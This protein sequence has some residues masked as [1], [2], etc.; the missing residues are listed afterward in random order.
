MGFDAA[1]SGQG[2]LECNSVG[3]IQTTMGFL[4]DRCTFPR[5]LLAETV[6]IAR[7]LHQFAGGHSMEVSHD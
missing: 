1:C 2:F 4:E 3:F 7:H 5:R 6:N